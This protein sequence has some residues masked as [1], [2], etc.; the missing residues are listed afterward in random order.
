MQQVRYNLLYATFYSEKFESTYIKHVIISRRLDILNYNDSNVLYTILN[1]TKPY[2]LPH[3]VKKKKLFTLTPDSNIIFHKLNLCCFLGFFGG[4][5]SMCS[6][7][8]MLYRSLFIFLSIF[9]WTIALSVF[10]F[11]ASRNLF[12]IFKLFLERI[13]NIPCSKLFLC[14]L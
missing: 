2:Y 6:F 3:C 14:L 9:F 12:G 11:T 7:F 13:L 5:C 8:I 1:V 4:G 10:R